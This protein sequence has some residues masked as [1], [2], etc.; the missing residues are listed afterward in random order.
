MPLLLVRHASALRRHDWSSPDFRRPLTPK[1]YAQ[2]AAL[3]D[4]LAGYDVRRILSSPYV[5]CVETVEP[6]A[7]RLGLPVEPV[8][9]LAEGAGASFLRLVDEVETADGAAVL[10]SHG[11]VLPI[12]LEALAPAAALSDPSRPC[13]KGSTWVVAADRRRADYLP[14]PDG[15]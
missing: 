14:P 9:A 2:A 1:G 11:D 13:D 3:A 8:D 7:A 5:R 15:S 12:L 6:L 4:Q 10:C